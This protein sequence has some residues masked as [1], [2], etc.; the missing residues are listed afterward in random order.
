M[1]TFVSPQVTTQLRTAH[2]TEQL[3]RT[4]ELDKWYRQRRSRDAAG[5]VSTIQPVTTA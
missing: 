5:Y 4:T 2:S 3:P 1:L